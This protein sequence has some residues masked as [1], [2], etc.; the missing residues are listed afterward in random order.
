MDLSF[1]SSEELGQ[2]HCIILNPATTEQ[3]SHVA[4]ETFPI[5]IRLEAVT[6]EGVHA[7]HSLEEVGRGRWGKG[8]ACKCG[9]TSNCRVNNVVKFARLVCAMAALYAPT[10]RRCFE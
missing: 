9:S 4:G 1:P 5:I 10:C 6:E 3:L 7:G 8:K 2:Q